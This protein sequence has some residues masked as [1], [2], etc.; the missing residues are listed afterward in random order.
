[1]S[2][3]FVPHSLDSL[4]RI[5]GKEPEARMY[6]GGTDL[7]VRLRKNPVNQFP[8]VCLGQI[9]ELKGVRES[10]EGT[11]IGA[12]SSHASLLSNPIIRYAFPVLAKGLQV[13][14]SPPIRNMGTIGGNIC[15]ASPAG[16][17][18]PPLYVLDA[19]L[20]IRSQNAVRRIAIKDFI[21][22]PGQQRLNKGEILAGIWLKNDPDFNIHH[23]E[24]VGQRN[25]LAIS[26]ASLSAL[27]KVSESG[28]IE[29]VR[30]AWGSV[31]PTIVSP[32]NV[33]AALKGHFLSKDTLQKVMPLLREAISPID[34]IRATAAYRRT[35]AGNILLR[36]L[37]SFP[38]KEGYGT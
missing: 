1:M 28:I 18:L 16:D 19:V 8:L 35:V 30:L 15:T 29:R 11:F 38:Y 27:L 12:C 7:L 26:V 34:D 23:F 14:G 13:L 20:E 6:A 21:V 32:T 24:K 5:L 36:L 9:K 3:V 22:G 17:T 33:E 4:W 37:A 2:G 10:P 31:A 25:A